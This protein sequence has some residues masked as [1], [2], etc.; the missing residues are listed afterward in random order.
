MTLKEQLLEDF[1]ISMREKD[2]L[3]KETLQICRAAILQVEKDK[4]VVLDDGDVLDILS[5]EYKKRAET[6]PEL[7]DREDI[8]SKYKAEME[9]ISHYLP[10]PLSDEEVGEVVRQAIEETGALSIRDMGAVMKFVQA[11]TKGR[12]DGKQI[13][14]IVRKQLGS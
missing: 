2:L 7:R 14:T 3:R 11:K 5:K 9:I 1:R 8:L 13:N 10:I 6:L 12:A 4:K